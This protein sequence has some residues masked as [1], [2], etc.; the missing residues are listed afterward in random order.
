MKDGVRE[1]VLK[2]VELGIA[3]ESHSPWASPVVPVPKPDGSVRVCIDYRRL[4][5]VTVGDPYYMCTLDEI[6]ERVSTS[7]VISKLDLA[8]GFY[9]IAVDRESVDKTA[10][11]TPYG[12]FAFLRMP[13]GL[14]NAPAVFQRTMEVVLGGCYTF[15]APYIDDIIVFSKDGEEHVRHL[16]SVFDALGRHS[17]T[18]KTLKCEFGKRQVE[19]L[20]H[21]IG[22][23]VLAI[24]H[25]R[26]V[27]MADYITPK[28]KKHLRAF[29]GAASYYRRFVQGF[30]NYS[31]ELSP[32]TSKA[33]PGVVGWTEV[34]L[35]AFNHLKVCLYNACMLTIPSSED[36][37][38]LHTDASGAGG[39]GAT[40]NVQRNGKKFPVAFFSKQ[41]QGAQHFYSATELECLAI[42]KSIHYFAHFLYGR[43]FTVITDHR[44]LVSF[45]TSRILNK[46]LLGW[47]L[48]LLDFDFEIIYRPGVN[49]QDADALSRQSWDSSTG[50]PCRTIEGADE[51]DCKLGRG[52]CGDRP[53]RDSSRDLIRYHLAH[54]T[55]D[56]TL[57]TELSTWLRK[58]ISLV[59][60]H[61]CTVWRRTVI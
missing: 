17:L 60:Y 18:V 25:H 38:S 55:L 45:L 1:E 61:A 29:L 50:D 8:K 43:C 57:H 20:G 36:I 13:F 58:F 21:V 31:S 7:R 9:Q 54:G 2:L 52:R 49:H 37:F 12:K 24:P 33:A 59:A 48:Q 23:G 27:A 14:K 53:H 41:L 15:A 40:L 4:N 47:V 30:A 5:A 46:R 16:R 28:T 44:A 22:N 56:I 42:F 6:L 26:A 39:I 3:V 32:A 19:Y 11:I 10:F 51:D 34:M 35:E